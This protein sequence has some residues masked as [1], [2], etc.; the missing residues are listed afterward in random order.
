MHGGHLLGQ[1]VMA[2]A[3]TVEGDRRVPVS[4]HTYFLPSGQAGQ[5]L[6]YKVIRTPPHGGSRCLGPCCATSGDLVA[7]VARQGLFTGAV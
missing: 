2:A 6:R 1:A 4:L 3:A 7:T 5:P